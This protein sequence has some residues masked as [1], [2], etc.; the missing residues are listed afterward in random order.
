M[1]SPAGHA[2]VLT[3]RV[4][5][6]A[7]LLAGSVLLFGWLAGRYDDGPVADSVD[8]ERGYY[9]TRAKLT[10][11]G[12][13]GD[14]RIVVRANSIEQRLADESVLLS[15]L[16]LDYATDRQ[17]LWHVT[18][19]RGRMTGDRVSLLLAGDVR[20]TGAAD[21]TGA[22]TLIVTDELAYDTRTNVIQTAEP[23]AVRFGPHALQGRG[24]RVQLNEGTL[25]LESNV[26]GRFTP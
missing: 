4:V 23:V 3:R 15:Q 8:D 2:R 12:P 10:E 21:G 17:G 16:E 1:R 11:L 20:V 9:L 7:A 13:D 19:D 25:R 22:E 5:T 26:H 24:L 18:A 6:I 14:P